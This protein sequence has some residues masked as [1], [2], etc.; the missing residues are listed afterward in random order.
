MDEDQAT[1]IRIFGDEICNFTQSFIKNGEALISICVILKY[2]RLCRIVLK[3]YR[4]LGYFC[5]FLSHSYHQL[6]KEVNWELLS[7]EWINA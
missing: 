2:P 7:M 3:I 4:Q 6:L 1:D 5:L